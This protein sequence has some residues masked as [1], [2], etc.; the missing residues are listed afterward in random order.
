M[1]RRQSVIETRRRYAPL[2]FAGADNSA[3]SSRRASA[4]SSAIPTLSLATAGAVSLDGDAQR[5]RF[6]GGLRKSDYVGPSAKARYLDVV[7]RIARKKHILDVDLD[8]EKDVRSTLAAPWD[9]GSAAG[10]PGAPD[11]GIFAAWNSPRHAYA[12]SCERLHRAAGCLPEPVFVRASF[13]GPGGR[14]REDRVDLAHRALG[15]G[16]ATAFADIVPY[17]PKLAAL[18][19]ADN[20]LSDAGISAVLAAVLPAGGGGC[21][22]LTEL[23]LSR[24]DVDGE[25]VRAIAAY[26]AADGCALEKLALDAADLDDRE[27]GVLMNAAARNERLS[28]LSLRSN[29]M[30]GAGEKL[31]RPG[32]ASPRR[33]K[34]RGALRWRDYR[35]GVAI[36]VMLVENCHLLRLDLAWNA[37]GASSG[38]AIGG[39]L[40]RNRQLQFLDLGYTSLGET[41]CAALGRALDT[42]GRLAFLG[43]SRAGVGPKAAMVLAEGLRENWAL[44]TLDVSGNPVGFLGGRA[45]CHVLNESRRPSRTICIDDCA[46]DVRPPGLF[47]ADLAAGK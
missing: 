4:D 14:A 21:P 13:A 38:V 30:G 36:G 26:V 20:R 42:N 22:R 43:L 3:A 29:V 34:E 39:G 24:N 46:L 31:V 19:F 27:C 9:E 33:P 28:E 1:P 35:G 10:E 11:A 23:D 32:Y 40:A 12:R 37:L 25:A 45:L 5:A 44:A 8:A 18:S 6:P 15:D 41:G 47:D 16:L 7:R 2:S 17:L